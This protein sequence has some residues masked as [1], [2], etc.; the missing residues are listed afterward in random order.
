MSTLPIS[1]IR[2]DFQRGENLIEETVLAYVADIQRGDRLQPLR[3][4]FDG[5]SYFLKD[6]FHRVEAAKRCGIQALE[7]EILPGTLEEMEAEF[8]EYVNAVRRSL[9]Q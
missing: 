1:A 4:R 3:V 6:G 5:Q 8:R 2:L 9:T 7:A